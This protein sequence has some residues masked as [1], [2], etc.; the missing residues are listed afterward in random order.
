MDPGWESRALVQL[1][2]DFSTLTG[3]GGG[4]KT[5]ALSHQKEA[6]HSPCL[7][8]SFAGDKGPQRPSKPSYGSISSPPNAEPQQPPP[9]ATYLNEK[10][11]VLDI[12]PV[13]MPETS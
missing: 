12:E 11:P 10:I 8:G 5:L 3:G 4:R 2:L 9:G 7:M 13:G 1:N 6:S